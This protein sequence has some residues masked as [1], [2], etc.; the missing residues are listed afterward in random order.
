MLVSCPLYDFD[1]I[2]LVVY[3]RYIMHVNF[4][5]LDRQVFSSSQ[6][7]PRP[8]HRKAKPLILLSVGFKNKSNEDEAR[9]CFKHGRPRLFAGIRAR[10]QRR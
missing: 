2:L 1:V 6:V 10:K 5:R 7:D 8:Q 3:I 9:A 4:A